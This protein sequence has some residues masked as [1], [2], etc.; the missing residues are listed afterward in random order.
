[1]WRIAVLH[2]GTDTNPAVALLRDSLHRH[3]LTD[4]HTCVIDVAGAERRLERLPDLVEDLLRQSPDIVVAIGAVAALVAQRATSSIPVLHATVLDPASI[5]LTARN[6]AGVTTF[7][8]GH[9]ARQVQW[10]QALLPRLRTVVCFVDPDAPQDS[11][12]VSPLLFHFRQA[13]LDA[14][15]RVH[16]VALQA[17]GFDADGMLATVR[18]YGAEALV[19]LEL[20][21][22]L[23]QLAEIA[24]LAERCGLPTVFPHGHGVRGLVMIG[25]GLSD[26]IDPLVGH[27]VAVS[28]GVDVATLP[29]R[30]VRHDRLML[31]RAS[32]RRLGLVIPPELLVRVTD[33]AGDE[34]RRPGVACP[35]DPLLGAAA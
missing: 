25:P 29:T 27:I 1:M 19:A 21:A 8:S 4:G 24:R 26:A 17:A 2:H 6:V 33:W 7:D 14:G 9:G 31:D 11:R 23:G 34:A 35:G 28:R 13:A 32:A 12:G 10:L 20:P 3:G 30:W 5:G 16:I 15:L 22:V 18:Q